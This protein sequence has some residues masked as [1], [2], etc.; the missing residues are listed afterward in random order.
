M[1]G[2][3][4]ARKSNKMPPSSKARGVDFAPDP[5]IS[6][7]ASGHDRPRLKA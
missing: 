1:I 6:I 2:Q 5:R 3:I 4:R 7:P